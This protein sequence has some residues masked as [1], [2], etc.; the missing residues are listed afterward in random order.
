MTIDE[1]ATITQ[2]VIAQ[3]GFD[4]FMPTA[5]YPER[6]E[7]RALTGLPDDVEPAPAVLKWA[8]GHAKRNEEV[9]IAFKSGRSEFTISASR[10]RN[11]NPHR[12][13]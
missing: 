12:S 1:F 13:K 3:D 2:H 9:L 5:C 11:A 7:I 4:E 10:A 6:P 8:L